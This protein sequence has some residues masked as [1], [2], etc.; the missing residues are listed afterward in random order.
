MFADALDVYGQSV[1]NADICIVGAGPA[2]L[3]LALELNGKGIKVLL[4]EAGN[5]DDTP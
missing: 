2:G 5:F 3:T 4:L 1:V